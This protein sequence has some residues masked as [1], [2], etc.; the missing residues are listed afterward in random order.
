MFN[1]R[2]PWGV[3]A[4]VTLLSLGATACDWSAFRYDAAH[5]GASPDMSIS[6]DAVAGSMVANWSA[7]TGAAIFSS[8][9][10]ANGIVYVGSND[11]KLYASTPRQAPPSGAPPP[12]PTSNLRRRWPMGSSTSG[13]WTTTCT[14]SMLARAQPSGPPT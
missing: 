6:K 3:L 14:P 7:T 4:V 9:A 2:R 8:P 12:A 10:V 13:P 11:N 5:T 1:Q